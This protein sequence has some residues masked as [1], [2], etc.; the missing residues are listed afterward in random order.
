[1][2]Y[3][4]PELLEHESLFRFFFWMKHTPPAESAAFMSHTECSEVAWRQSVA[5][6]REYL[7]HVVQEIPWGDGLNPVHFALS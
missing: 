6:A 4:H 1:M 3:G 5:R 2:K 7:I